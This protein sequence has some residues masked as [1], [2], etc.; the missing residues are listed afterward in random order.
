[1]DNNCFYSHV[2]HGMLKRENSSKA[3][4]RIA[5]TTWSSRQIWRCTWYRTWQFQV[6]VCCWKRR[7]NPIFCSRVALPTTNWSQKGSHLKWSS[8]PRQSNSSC[9]PAIRDQPKFPYQ[10]GRKGMALSP[11][12]SGITPSVIQGGQ[13]LQVVQVAGVHISFKKTEFQGYKEPSEVNHESQQCQ[14]QFYNIT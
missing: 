12:L 10:E 4:R 11:W 2:I 6:Q 3:H 9:G 13:G 14:S 7:L 8:F 5:A 1:M